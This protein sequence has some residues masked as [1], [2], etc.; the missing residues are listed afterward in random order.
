MMSPNYTITRNKSAIDARFVTEFLSQSSYW[1]RGITEA[2]VRQSIDDSVCFAA[3]CE[4]QQ[5]GFGRLVTDNVT[6]AW[7]CD[8]FVNSQHRRN[9]LGKRLLR[10]M[11]DYIDDR[12]IGLV[13]CATVDADEFYI[14]YGDFARLEHPQDWLA[15]RR[16]STR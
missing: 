5:V 2:E 14:R 1:A 8:V 9:G 4:N 6:F 12:G 16:Q 10:T 13:L 3:F 11:L 7:L 15:R